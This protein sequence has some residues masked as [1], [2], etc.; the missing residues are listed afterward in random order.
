M[1]KTKTSTSRKKIVIIV[2]IIAASLLVSFGAYAITT[3]FFQ[4]DTTPGSSN[5]SSDSNTS[6]PS[7]TDEPYKQDNI[8]IDTPKTETPSPTVRSLIVTESDVI[9]NVVEVR[10][11]VSDLSEDGGTCSVT[12]TKSG[13]PSVTTQSSSFGDASTTQCG[14]L[15]TPVST[16]SAKGTWSFTLTYTSTRNSATATGTVT[17]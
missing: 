4:P 17:L 9:D 13:E 14:V 11:Y 3:G 5:T 12:F 2:A 1:L 10:A 15:N 6:S 7:N 8:Q 16:F